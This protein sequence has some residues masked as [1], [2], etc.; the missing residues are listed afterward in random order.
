M[1]K[2]YTYV[3]ALPAPYE[4]S[5]K[6]ICLTLPMY[7]YGGYHLPTKRIL[8]SVLTLKKN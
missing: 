4:T 6:D 1:N 2:D 3:R 7:R 8:N 5:A